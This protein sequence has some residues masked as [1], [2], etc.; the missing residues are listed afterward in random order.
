MLGG[1]KITVASAGSSAMEGSPASQYSIEIAKTH[2]LDL[3]RHRARLLNAAMV[4]D[5]DL[6]VTMGVRHRET[7]GAI[8]PDALEYTFLL[9]NFSDRHHGDV[10]DPIGGPLELYRST[11][12]VI[13]ECV[14]SMAAH[15]PRFDGWKP[16]A[17]GRKERS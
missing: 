3:S 11:Y 15:L 2:G 1:A 7:V 10:P 9:T 17:R 12:G 8:D 6:I 14:E 16:A 13:R 4:R 5:A